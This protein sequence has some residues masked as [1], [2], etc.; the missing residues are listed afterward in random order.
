[1]ER[2]KNTKAKIFDPSYVTHHLDV[3]GEVNHPLHL[4]ADELRAMELTEVKDLT[5]IC[6]SGRNEGFIQSYRG[7]LL[8]DLL[9]R[10]DVIMREHNSPSHL[11]VTVMSSDDHWILF[12]YQELYN[13]P[14]GEQA[15]VIIEKDGQ[16]LGDDEGEFSFV[17]AN[18]TRLG[19]R[20]LRYLKSIEVHE[21]LWNKG[22]E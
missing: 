10:A 2:P 7:V 5:M 15:I 9:N 11:Y 19:A 14:I 4:A 3:K 17:S 8:T 20:K 12:S 22:A 18:D 6:G 1:M 16:P 21:H 13:S